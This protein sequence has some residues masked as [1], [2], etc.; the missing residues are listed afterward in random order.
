MSNGDFAVGGNERQSQESDLPPARSPD[1]G[2]EEARRLRFAGG[3]P[4]PV[5]GG[6]HEGRPTASD[7]AFGGGKDDLDGALKPVATPPP[8]PKGVTKG[9]HVATDRAP[10]V[11]EVLA[12]EQPAMDGASQGDLVDS[13]GELVDDIYSGVLI[14]QLGPLESKLKQVAPPPETPLAFEI[15]GAIVE[16]IATAATDFLG[17]IAIEK[18]KGML[19]RA[20]EPAMEGVKAIGNDVGAAAKQ[21]VDG[22][23]AEAAA[24]R[25]DPGGNL[26]GEF[27]ERERLQLL[28]KKHDAK[29]RLRLIRRSAA[30][31]LPHQLEVLDAS[32]RS[33]LGDPVL[34]A[35]FEHKTTMEWMNF[36]TRVSLGKRADGQDTDMPGA[37][38]AGGI[39]GA[40]RRGIVA[41]NAGH[42][43]MIDVTIDV[44]M[45]SDGSAPELQ[46]HDARA[47]AGTGAAAVLRSASDE[48]DEHGTPY[49]LA[50]LPVYRR[51]W[52]KTGASRLDSFPAFVITPEGAIEADL[53]DPTLAS[54]GAGRSDGNVPKGD[55][56]IGAHL[57]LSMLRGIGTEQLQ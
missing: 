53:D 17:R 7:L 47:E 37:N 20:V 19:G 49:T 26:L 2:S 57:V 41:W 42:G 34:T 35:W 50:T 44:S 5:G 6:F 22:E 40:G 56:M 36:C 54:I 9:H 27:I 8:A 4:A 30:R 55:A 3:A 46:F 14:G 45:G 11:G 48:R 18:V 43:G 10:S 13:V 23:A 15:L 39:A 28:Q 33:L 52:L 29:D 24:V 21:G 25:A 1:V 12:P 51:V 38:Q 31:E 32:L 16:G